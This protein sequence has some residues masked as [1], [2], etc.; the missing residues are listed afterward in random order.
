[1]GINRGFEK[2][3]QKEVQKSVKNGQFTSFYD[4]FWII[5]FRAIFRNVIF[6]WV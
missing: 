6:I 3:A 5:Y 4:P 1:M 2:M